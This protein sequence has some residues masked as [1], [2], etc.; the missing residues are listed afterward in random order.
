M[1]LGYYLTFLWIYFVSLGL[2]G[3]FPSSEPYLIELCTRQPL[4]FGPNCS[5]VCHCLDGDCDAR[6]EGVGCLSGKCSPGF[7]GFPMC[8]DGNFIARESLTI[9]LSVFPGQI[10]SQL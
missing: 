8:Q 4:S 9:P 5:H 10:W 3:E 7:T 1:S 6:T 2:S